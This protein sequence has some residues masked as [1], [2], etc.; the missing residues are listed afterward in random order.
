MVVDLYIKNF[1]YGLFYRLDPGV[2]ELHY[3]SGICKNNMIVLSVKIGLLILSMIRSKLMASN[4]L[5]F[6]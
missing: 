1:F 5:T 2:T 6:Q 4:Q 3:L